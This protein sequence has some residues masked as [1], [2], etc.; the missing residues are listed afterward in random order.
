MLP[1]VLGARV[2]FHL[3]VLEFFKWHSVD[4]IRGKSGCTIHCACR[5]GRV[6]VR[7]V[8]WGWWRCVLRLRGVMRVDLGLLGNVSLK[9]SR[10]PLKLSW[11]VFS[12]VVGDVAGVSSGVAARLLRGTT[13]AGFI[14]GPVRG[15]LRE[16]RSVVRVIWIIGTGPLVYVLSV[17]LMTLGT[18]AAFRSY[19]GAGG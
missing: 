8:V 5:A 17:L 4:D 13:R 7:R 3:R 15:M 1:R 19:F 6:A 2:V 9:I 11:S 16:A 10:V 14:G 12:E 18:G